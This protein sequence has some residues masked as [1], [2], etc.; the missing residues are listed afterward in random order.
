MPHLTTRN[1]IS[2]ALIALYTPAL[3]LSLLLTARHGLRRSSGWRFLL[4]FSLARLLAAAFQLSTIA[5]PSDASLYIGEWVLLGIALSPL[6]LVSLGLLS[7]VAGS[8]NKTRP[9]TA[10]TITPR[11]VR[12]VQVLNAAG[13]A[14]AVAG[15]VEAAGNVG[16]GGRVQVSGL[17]KGAVGLFVASFVAIV[18]IAAVVWKDVA[19]AEPGE[20]RLLVAVGGTTP[21]LLVRV[22]YT[23]LSVYTGE[24]RFN[25]VM[26][27]VGY[28]LGMALVMELVIVY[29]FLGVGLTLKKVGKGEEREV[30]GKVEMSA[31]RMSA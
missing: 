7:R 6:E 29:A 10:V 21:F 31:K 1:N 12:M 28:L 19:C 8:I 22:V 4:T 14:L 20:K 5:H 23:A 9:E 26:G 30:E 16:A 27:D 3:L 11:H 17:T 13:L 15:G 25:P 18:G 24:M 2:I